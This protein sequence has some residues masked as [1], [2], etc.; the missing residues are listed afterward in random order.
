[1]PEQGRTSRTRRLV[2]PFESIARLHAER[3]EALTAHEPRDRRGAGLRHRTGARAAGRSGDVAL[4]RPH[5]LVEL[6]G[7]IEGLLREHAPVAD[8][9]W[10]D[11]LSIDID[12]NPTLIADGHQMLGSFR[13]CL[14]HGFLGDA[15][16][17]LVEAPISYDTNDNVRRGGAVLLI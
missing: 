13:R 12:L 8:E 5:E 11:R 14:M 7:I 10:L 2:E 9:L 17:V 3:D 4:D 1:V 6:A 15:R 16:H